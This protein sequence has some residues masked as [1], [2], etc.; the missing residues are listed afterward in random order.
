M[1]CGK[2]LCFAIYC[3]LISVVL[4]YF[5][6]F[7]A[8]VSTY[9]ELIGPYNTKDSTAVDGHAGGWACHVALVSCWV[10]TFFQQRNDITKSMKKLIAITLARKSENMNPWM[11]SALL[12]FPHKRC[13]ILVAGKVVWHGRILILSRSLGFVHTALQPNLFFCGL[14][15]VLAISQA[16]NSMCIYIYDHHIYNME[17]DLIWYDLIEYNATQYSQPIVI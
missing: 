7:N 5:D 2:C 11:I 1:K 12:I 8:D 13:R 17:H 3:Y 6:V 15:G 9:Q 16:A 14:C 4:Y 10:C